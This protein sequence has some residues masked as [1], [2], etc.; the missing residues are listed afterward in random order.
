MAIVGTKDSLTI[1]S[2]K[3]TGEEIEASTVNYLF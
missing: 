2:G 1:I 3:N